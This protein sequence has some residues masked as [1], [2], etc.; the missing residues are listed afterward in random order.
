[1]LLSA[2]NDNGTVSD[3][4]VFLG[5]LNLKLNGSIGGDTTIYAEIY[6]PI[7]IQAL[8]NLG[9]L[10]VILSNQIVSR[11]MI[12]ILTHPKSKRFYRDLISVN[13]NEG[14]DAIDVD[15]VKA[16]EVLAFNESELHFSCQSEFVHSFY[17]ASNKK[18]MCIGIKSATCGDGKVRFLCDGMDKEEDLIVRP[19]DDLVLILY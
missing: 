15:I 18:K 7:N 4:D 17:Y 10:S 11:F 16:K 1:M 5:A 14:D 8:R 13:D 12:Q 9:V 2:V 3:A 6:N 19:E